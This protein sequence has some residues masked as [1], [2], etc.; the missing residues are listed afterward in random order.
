MHQFEAFVE[1]RRV[2]L[3]RIASATRGEMELGDIIND[4]WL[5]AMEI[6]EGMDEPSTSPT[7]NTRT[8]YWHGWERGMGSMR[9][10]RFGAR[11]MWLIH[12]FCFMTA[13]PLCCGKPA[14]RLGGV[15]FLPSKL[16]WAELLEWSV[17]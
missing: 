5:I 11:E 14:T 17:S 8:S 3:R 10:R 16:R 6:G 1:A 12:W 4:V 9:K 15:S 13:R 2:D 7:S